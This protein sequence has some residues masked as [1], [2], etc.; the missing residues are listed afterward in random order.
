MRQRSGHFLECPVSAQ[1]NHP[2]HSTRASAGDL[3]GMTRTLRPDFFDCNP[4]RLQ[5][6]SRDRYDARGAARGRIHDEEERA[7]AQKLHSRKRSMPY[8]GGRLP[9]DVNPG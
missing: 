6:V 4:G 3:C 7:A 1:H 2:I 8:C 5:H 9:I